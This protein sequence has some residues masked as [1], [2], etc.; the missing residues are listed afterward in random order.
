L[1]DNSCSNTSQPTNSR[2]SM[3]SHV[4]SCSCFYGL[5]YW[6][7]GQVVKIQ[8]KHAINRSWTARTAD[9]E[10]IYG[11]INCSI[12]WPRP[13]PTWAAAG[14]IASVSSAS[15]CK[16][17]DRQNIMH[18]IIRGYICKTGR[19]KA[20]WVRSCRHA[21]IYGIRIWLPTNIAD[22]AYTA[23]HAV[24]RLF[25]TTLSHRK[26]T[27]LTFLHW[28]MD[29]LRQTESLRSR[30]MGVKVEDLTRM[31]SRGCSAGLY[32]RDVYIALGSIH[33]CIM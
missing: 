27:T 18:E 25:Y 24:H 12:Y 6:Q 10:S 33:A 5:I 17:T 26:T 21:G 3:T 32:E 20:Q 7:W 28:I 19:Q 2:W 29:S 8:D 30:V 31:S 13:P 4:H 9:R 11:T 16:Y 23:R 22:W 14:L 1:P 15:Q